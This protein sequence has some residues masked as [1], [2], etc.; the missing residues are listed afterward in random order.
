MMFIDVHNRHYWIH[1]YGGYQSTDPTNIANDIEWMTNQTNCECWFIYGIDS[2]G[3]IIL[4]HRRSAFLV[5]SR[6]LCRMF[7]DACGGFA[8]S[9]HQTHRPGH[10]GEQQGQS[11]EGFVGGGRFFSNLH[12]NNS[13]K[14]RQ[15]MAMIKKNMWELTSVDIP[16]ELGQRSRCKLK[17]KTCWRAAMSYSINYP[18]VIRHSCWTWQFI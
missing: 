14:H 1:L 5:D 7:V 4:N 2:Y 11:R 10:G 16:C 17:V 8:L 12:G 6:R 9:T 15:W 3:T 13:N 18:L